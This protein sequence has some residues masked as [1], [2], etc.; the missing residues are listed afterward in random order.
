MNLT[1]VKLRRNVSSNMK[2]F[3]KISLLSLLLL[4]FVIPQGVAEAYVSVSGYYRSDGTY[5][6]PHV[7]SNPNGLLYDNYSWRPS[8]GLYNST[9][10][11]RGSYWDTPTYITDPDYYEGQSL[12]ESGQSGVTNSYVP[13]IN[14]T[15]K[16]PVSV[17]VDIPENASLDY[18]GTGWD[19]NRGYKEN[20]TKGTC[21]KVVV[22]QNASLDYFGSGWDCN[23][24]YKENYT[25]GTCEKV[26]IP[27]NASLD[28]F[29]SG[30][31][32]NRGYK[33]NYSR[34]TCEK[35]VVPQNASLDYF[36]SGWDCNRGYKENY[37]T[38]QCEK[39]V[40][41]QNASLDYFGS[42]W[43]CNTG[44]MRA[45]NDCVLAR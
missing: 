42:G 18:W 45:G 10:G 22:P 31:D 41:P 37:S 20:Y 28:Y 44:Y 27:A 1:Y 29:G 14:T 7:R 32:C 33:E 26:E 11:A 17:D 24:G 13:T 38:N 40:V 43:N 21:E 39:V 9:Y 3:L 16:K 25:K 23:R 15:S 12:Y 34:G 2:F 36:G 4:S 30:W 19:C 8:Q 5:V 6:R 35:V